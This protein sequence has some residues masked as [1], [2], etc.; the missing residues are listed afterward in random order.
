MKTR[1]SI[2]RY[3]SPTVLDMV[4]RDLSFLLKSIQESNGELDLQ[5]RNEY[6]NIYYKG[7]S[8]AR[9]QPKPESNTYEFTVSKQFKLEETIKDLNDNRLVSS[10]IFLEP[11]TNKN[12]ATPKERKY[13]VAKVPATLIHPFFQKKV[14][15][16]LMSHIKS[17]GNGEEITFEQSLMT[18]NIDREDF[19]II[20]RQVQTEGDK[21]RRRMDLLALQQLPER[22]YKFVILEVKLGNNKELEGDVAGQLEEYEKKIDSHFSSFKDCYEENY[23]QKRQ[24]GVIGDDSWAEEISI[25]KPVDGRIIVGLYSGIGKKQLAILVENHPNLKNKIDEF[26][27]EIR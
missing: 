27:N 16:K 6:F 25:I 5:L 22:K 1:N 18:G 26:W 2:K 15:A 14:V 4:Q 3:L 20:D 11:K 8:L 13:S 21:S 9:I 19:I 7:N 12:S 10:N 23:R 17:H 24:L